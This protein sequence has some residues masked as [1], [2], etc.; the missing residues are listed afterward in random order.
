M[1]MKVNVMQQGTVAEDDLIHS[2]WHIVVHQ[3]QV[4][5]LV[6][7]VV[8]PGQR[9]GGEKVKCELAV[10]LWVLELLA[11]SGRFRGIRVN[12]FVL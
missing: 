6:G 12:A 5:R 8:G 10:R 3:G 7:L 4:G 11:G 1:I 9:N 2:L